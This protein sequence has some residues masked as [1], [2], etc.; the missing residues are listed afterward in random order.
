MMFIFEKIKQINN[1]F[2]FEEKKMWNVENFCQFFFRIRKRRKKL[3]SKRKE[4]VDFFFF[5]IF[6][7]FEGFE[8]F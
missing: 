5:V 4:E 8:K 2:Q 7:K 3:V 1:L 6:W